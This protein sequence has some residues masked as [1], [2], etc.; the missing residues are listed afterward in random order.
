L[1]DRRGAGKP[2]AIRVSRVDSRRPRRAGQSRA[3]G[4]CGSRESRR[5]RIPASSRTGWLGQL[6]QRSDDFGRSWRPIDEGLRSEQ[7]PDPTAE[8]DHCIHHIAMRPKRPDV[9]FMR[10]HGDV[11]RGDDGADARRE[12]F[13]SRSGG[14]EWEA[15]SKGLPHEPCHVNVVRDAMAGG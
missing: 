14:Q 4:S 9:L 7:I 5:S 15:L 3:T 6:I 1:D 10:K 12:V 8:V 13:R 11:M 2:S